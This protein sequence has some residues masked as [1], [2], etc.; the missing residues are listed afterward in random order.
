MKGL[1][2]Y[3]R[4]IA[5]GREDVNYI[6]TPEAFAAVRLMLSLIHI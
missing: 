1:L 5:P 4:L 3:R 2:K 6:H